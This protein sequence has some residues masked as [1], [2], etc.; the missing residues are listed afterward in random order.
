MLAQTVFRAGKQVALVLGLDQLSTR[1]YTSLRELVEGWGK[2][3]YAAGADT[4]PIKGPAGRILLPF[5]LV[6]PPIAMLAPPVLAMLAMIGAVDVSIAPP[7]AATLL[8]MAG[9]AFIYR[10]FGVS[11][12]FGALYPLAAAVLLYIEVRAIVRGRRVAWKGRSYQ[13]R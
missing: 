3:I 7:A 4:L 11:P 10:A 8:L 1:M 5:L 6:A 9:W 12:L 2:N 13:A